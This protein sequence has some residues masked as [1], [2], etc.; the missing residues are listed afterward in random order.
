[1]TNIQTLNNYNIHIYE[2]FRDLKHSGKLIFDNNDLCKIFE[3]Y[4]CIKLS[5]QYN[6]QFYEYSDIDPTFKEHNLMSK[7]DTGIDACNLI[8]TIVQCK[9][10]KDTLSW[11]ECSTFFGSQ[12]SFCKEQNK[13][14][15]KWSNLIITRNDDCVLSKNLQDRHLLFK[16]TTFSK[17][18]I[19]EYCENLIKNPPIYPQIIHNFNLRDYQIESINLIKNN[20]KNIIVCIPTGTGKNVIIIHSFVIGLKYLILVPR[21]ILMDQLKEEI[22]KFIPTFKH[23]IQLIGDGNNKFN[24]NKNITIC[25]FNSVNI[26]EKYA[27]T[28]DKIFVDEAHHICIPEIYTID[29]DDNTD[30]DDNDDNDDTNNNLK[31]VDDSEDEIKETTNYV[32]IIKIFTQYNNNVYLSATID[33]QPNFEFYKKDIRDMINNKYLCDYTIHVPIFSN[34]PTNTHVCQYLLQK[35]RNIIVYCN[36]RKEGLAINKLF[37]K[38]QF[39]SSEYID[40][41]TNKLQRNS[42]I[43]RYKEGKIP[44]LVNVRILVE[45]F[46]APISKGVCFLHLPKSGNT[47]IQIIGRALR[48]HPLKTI[49]NIILPYSVSDDGNSIT[50]FLKIIARNDS[51]IKQSFVSK[52]ICGYFSIDKCY[53]VDEEDNDTIM[54]DIEFKYDLIFDSMGALTNRKDIW[55]FKKQLLFEYCNINKGVPVRKIIYKNYKIG[56]WLQTQKNKINDVNSDIY[57]KLSDNVYVKNSLNDYLKYLDENKDKEKITWNQWKILLFEYCNI[58]KS[59]PTNK[60]IYKSYKI[61]QWLQDQKKKINDIN[62]DIYIKLSENIYVKNS[63]DDYLKYLDENKNKEKITWNQWK[64]LLFEYCNI[65][66]GVPVRKIIY[67]N[68]KIGLWLQTQKNKINDVNSD[69]YIKLSDNVYVKNSLNDYLK[70]LD[71]NKDKEKITWNNWKIL[72]FEYCNINK[73]VPANKIIYKNHKIGKWLQHQ[74]SKINDVNSDIYIKLSENIYVKNS[75]DDYLNPDNIWNNWKIL[76]FEY[77]NINKRVPIQRI[78]YKNYKIGQWLQN[79]KNKINNV[80]SDIYIKLSENVYVKNS[81]DNY[82]KNKN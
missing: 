53:D 51:R 55:E 21:I 18:Q 58:N 20:K 68:Y 13:P 34:D 59:V 62:S 67:K 16:D 66:K 17:K 24:P 25:V 46:D 69:I 29:N 38:L 48:L 52:N 73:S 6:Q 65:N 56:L 9:L 1:M 70:Y 49:A 30:N 19:I 79:Q 44:F 31:L 15:V 32:Q 36:S 4:S 54:E 37:N 77:C 82:L 14:V 40:C 63:L 7:N 50:N 42:I 11:K 45:G 28:F 8:D 22:I 76:L 74:K 80:N 61:G 60:I 2:R 39:G 57:I 47:L 64:I 35:Y 81:L 41:Y 3:Y 33:K 23:N 75:L 71:E 26:V 12:V 27:N 72:L 78:T 43:R 5:L 10:R